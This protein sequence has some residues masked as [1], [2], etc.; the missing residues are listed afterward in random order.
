M[1]DLDNFQGARKKIGR[2]VLGDNRLQKKQIGVG[3]DFPMHTMT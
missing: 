3:G 1:G 2:K